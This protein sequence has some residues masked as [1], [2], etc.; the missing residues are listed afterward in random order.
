[1]FYYKKRGK[2]KKQLANEK[3]TQH[4]REMSCPSCKGHM[5]LIEAGTDRDTLVC[6]QCNAV[7][8]FTVAPNARKQS[9]TTELGSLTLRNRSKE[10]NT[11]N[12]CEPTQGYQD[13][14]DVIRKCMDDT[15]ILSFNYIS[16]N[17][18]K[19]ARQVEPYKLSRDANGDVV[20]FAYDIEAS[21]I[22]VFKLNGIGKLSI[23]DFDYK[24]RWDIEDKLRKVVK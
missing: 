24:P 16:V 12:K 14:L 9:D 2:R 13:T 18:K 20:L 11:P 19:S 1:M 10:T 17:G 15:K 22:K 23:Q 4:I 6:T 3:I 21:S 5:K 8:T 7:H